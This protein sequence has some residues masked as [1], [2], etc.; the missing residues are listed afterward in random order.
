MKFIHLYIEMIKE[1]GMITKFI[2][3]FRTRRSNTIENAEPKVQTKKKRRKSAQTL[4]KEATKLKK[5]K[6]YVEAVE[7]LNNAFAPETKGSEDL[8]LKCYLRL[9]MYQ[10]LAGLNDEAWVYMNDLEFKH[11]DAISKATIANQQRIFL[12]KEKRFK[13]ALV[14][15][16]W[17]ICK[18]LQRDIESCRFS[19]E[20]ADRNAEFERKYG[21]FDDDEEREIVRITEKGNPN[22]DL[23]YRH[24]SDRVLF[25][26]TIEGIKSSL[27]SIIKKAK[28][29]DF[30]EQIC[31][32]LC[33]YI[34]AS[35]NYKLS[36]VRDIVGSFTM[37]KTA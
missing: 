37:V 20:V 36:E 10:Q 19:D 12:K 28:M 13:D 30:E 16:M 25:N 1:A 18:E 32:R 3:L 23:S 34:R 17:S 8:T 27:S 33:N 26:S 9:P 24:L 29:T 14:Y 31:V 2:S 35:E 7:T 4:L 15:S 22:Y 11:T 5:E 6:R 21:G